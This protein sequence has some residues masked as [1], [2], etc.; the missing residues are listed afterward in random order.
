MLFFIDGGSVPHVVEQRMFEEGDED[1]ER[2][3]EQELENGADDG[4][5]DDDDD[6]EDDG[7]DD[8]ED[9]D[10]EDDD[11]DGIMRP[12]HFYFFKKF[13]TEEQAAE[14]VAC[15]SVKNFLKK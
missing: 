6:D 14:L 2:F 5:D 8:D 12:E 1:A 3:F 9:E 13:F 11:I 15:S 10:E 4:D 7:E